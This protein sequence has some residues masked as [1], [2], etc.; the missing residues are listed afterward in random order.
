MATKR[1]RTFISIE[2]D[3]DTK[4]AF[5]DK[6]EQDG[7]TATSVLKQFIEQYLSGTSENLPSLAEITQRLKHV[8]DKIQGVSL[9]NSHLVKEKKQ[10]LGESAA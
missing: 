10:L 4:K 5:N 6:V 9:E 7:K 1:S 3:P 2:I 8:E